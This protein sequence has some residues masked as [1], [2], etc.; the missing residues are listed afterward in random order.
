[1]YEKEIFWN[2]QSGTNLRGGKDHD[3]IRASFNL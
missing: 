2:Q 1:M 3:N